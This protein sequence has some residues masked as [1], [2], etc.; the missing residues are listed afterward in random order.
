LVEPSERRAIRASDGARPWRP[1]WGH[2]EFI[3]ARR[4]VGLSHFRLHDL[5]HF[6]ATQMRAAGVPIVSRGFSARVSTTL[7]V[8]AHGVPGGDRQAFETLA[9]IL[10]AAPVRL[11]RSRPWTVGASAPTTLTGSREEACAD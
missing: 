2:Q 9:N 6:M 1:N 10:G 7:N 3:H 8:Y 4:G 5:R 11:S